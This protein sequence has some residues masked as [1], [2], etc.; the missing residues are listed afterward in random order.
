MHRADCANALS[1]MSG[2]AERIID[3]EW[4]SES[5]GQFVASVEVKALDRPR[6]LQDVTSVLSDNHVNILDAK[7][8]V[9][10]DRVS[11]MRFEFELSDPSHLEMLLG[12]LRSI[13]SVY[14]AFRVVPGHS[15]G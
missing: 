15:S 10:R 4:D 9:G 11:K 13:E 12:R 2:E 3:V 8:H 1:L 6:L 14:D 7:S 5:T